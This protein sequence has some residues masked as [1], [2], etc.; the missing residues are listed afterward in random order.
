[1]RQNRTIALLI[2]RDLKIKKTSKIIDSTEAEVLCVEAS[3]YKRF[4]DQIH[5]LRNLLSAV[6]VS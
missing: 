6:V 5:A 2:D 4:Q 1:M 3:P